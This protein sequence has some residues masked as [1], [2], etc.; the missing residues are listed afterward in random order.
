LAGFA[1]EFEKAFALNAGNR[2]RAVQLVAATWVGKD[3][4]GHRTFAA[5]L[6]VQPQAGR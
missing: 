2:S 4:I 1:M 6:F 3:L 5:V